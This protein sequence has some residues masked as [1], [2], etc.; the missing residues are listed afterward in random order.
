MARWLW[1]H[2]A[3]PLT[4]TFA[5]SVCHSQSQSEMVGSRGKRRGWRCRWE[6]VRGG[7]WGGGGGGGGGRRALAGCVLAVTKTYFGNA[8]TILR[9]L[10]FHALFYLLVAASL[11]GNGGYCDVTL[12]PLT[13]PT[14]ALRWAAMRAIM[15]H[16]SEWLGTNSQL[17]Q[18]PH[19]TTTFEEKGEPPKR[20]IRTEVPASQTSLTPYRPRPNWPAHMD[21]YIYRSMA[22][23]RSLLVA[24][25]DRH[26]PFF[27][28][29]F[30]FDI[31]KIKNKKI[32][33][34]DTYK[35][36]NW[37]WSLSMGGRG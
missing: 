31:Y 23:P 5:G 2:F 15:F 27:F 24:Y 33:K 29:F 26:I 34:V 4:L 11:G 30:L 13:K 18:C 10:L 7:L 21:L 12:S 19:W 35:F 22:P 37:D 36:Q 14:S 16:N 32:K 25:S 17:R 20:Q 6:V 3:L 8:T 28:L 9:Q 1:Q